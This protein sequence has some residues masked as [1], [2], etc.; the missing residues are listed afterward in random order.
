MSSW[1]N[2]DNAANAPYW[3]VNT[4]INHN[5]PSASAPTAANV[6]LLYGNTQFEA[7]TQD[8]TVGLFMVDATETTSGGDNVTDVSLSN[9]GRGYVEAPSVTF[10]GGGGSSAAATA[11][12]AGGEVTNIT[13]TNVGSGYTSDPTVVLQVP[14]LTVPTGQVVA[15]NDTIMYTGHGQANGAALIFNWNGSA[16]IGGLLNGTTYYVA[17]QTANKF[18]LSTTAANAANNIVIDLT[19]TGG[20]GQYFTIV[21]ATRATGIA[22]RGLSQS[23]GGAEHATHIG[24]NLKTVGAGGR[25]GRVQYET[26]VAISEVK[27]DGSDDITLPDA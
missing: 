4:I 24:W 25:A 20:T 17:P 19:T 21:D 11:T 18:S 10:S 23:Q 14:V 6:A 5:A 27:G 1:G 12:V 22:S 15:A 8:T 26:L 9:Q 16:N 3:A 13:I 2:N 7:Y